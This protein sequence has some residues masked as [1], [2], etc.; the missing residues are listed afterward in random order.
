[1]AQS[2]INTRLPQQL[3]SYVDEICGPHGLYETASEFV[4]ELIRQHYEK[5][6]LHKWQNLNSKLAPGANADISE[7]EQVNPDEQLKQFKNRYK[8]GK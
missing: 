5:S 2:R 3:A 6:E 4:R 1:M 7:F 8:N